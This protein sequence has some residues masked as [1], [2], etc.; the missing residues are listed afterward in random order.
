MEDGK[1]SLLTQIVRIAQF[2]TV[3]SMNK[4]VRH[5]FQAS[6]EF[7]SR[8]TQTKLNRHLTFMQPRE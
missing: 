2:Q 6:T 5:L 7:Q 8:E 4:T 3:N 1:L